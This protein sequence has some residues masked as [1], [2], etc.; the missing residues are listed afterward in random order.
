MDG[1]FASLE[2][3]DPSLGRMRSY[4]LVAGTDL[5]VAWLVDVVHGRIGAPG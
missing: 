4:R 5:F 1:F 3:R 2:A